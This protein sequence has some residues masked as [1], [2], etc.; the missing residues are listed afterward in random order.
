MNL[1]EFID[2][3]DENIVRLKINCR[4]NKNK[5]ILSSCEDTRYSKWKEDL[6]NFIIQDILNLQSFDISLIENLEFSKKETVVM[7]DQ[8]GSLS[9]IK[10]EIKYQDLYKCYYP[11][12]NNLEFL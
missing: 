10:I 1:Q 12:I 3:F 7:C 8:N 6:H 9:L 11:L 4:N 2:K 5:I